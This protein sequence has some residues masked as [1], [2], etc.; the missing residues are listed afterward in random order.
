[1]DGDENYNSGGKNF[2]GGGGDNEENEIRE[3]P[4]KSLINTIYN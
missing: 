2:G 1:L 4:G 3:S